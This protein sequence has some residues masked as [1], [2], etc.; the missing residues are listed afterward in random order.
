MQIDTLA[1][2]PE[3]Q[4]LVA[5]ELKIDAEVGEQQVFK[6]AM[7]T[8]ALEARQHIL[9]HSA[10]KLLILG[11]QDDP[12]H[13][14]AQTLQKTALSQLDQKLYPK[15]GLSKE[16]AA[17]YH[18]RCKALL[19]DME[20]CLTTWQDLGDFFAQQR[21]SIPTD[22]FNESCFKLLDGFLASLAT[23]YSRKQQRLLYTPKS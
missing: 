9:P 13:Q 17:N 14:H 21:L 19:E 2:N 18:P 23:R 16:D 1:Y 7:M 10:L 22:G 5:L 4:T 12:H 8:A 6:Y 20:L 11:N 15:R 3:H